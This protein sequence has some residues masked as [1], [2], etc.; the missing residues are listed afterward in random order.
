VARRSR[1]VTRRETA[2]TLPVASPSKEWRQ[3]ILGRIEMLTRRN[4]FNTTL[5]AGAALATQGNA[6]EVLWLSQSE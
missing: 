2:Q 6:R 3:P 1:I 5:A 4:F